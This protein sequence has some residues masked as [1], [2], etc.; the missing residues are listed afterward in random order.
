[1]VY[2]VTNKQI[3]LS[4]IEDAFMWYLKLG[5]R[6]IINP[7]LKKGDDYDTIYFYS[8]MNHCKDLNGKYYYLDQHKS[9]NYTHSWWNNKAL[10]NNNPNLKNRD[11]AMLPILTDLEGLPYVCFTIPS[12]NILYKNGNSNHFRARKNWDKL[13]K[14]MAKIRLLKPDM[15]PLEVVAEGL[16]IKIPGHVKKCK[17]LKKKYKK[18]CQKNKNKN[19]KQNKTCKKLKHQMK[20]RSC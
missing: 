12:L 1:L 9:D 18:T 13:K 8:F 20:T 3:L 2:A 7:N 14:N 16:N 17:T 15:K 11:F 19:K 10:G 6:L 5:G 4:S